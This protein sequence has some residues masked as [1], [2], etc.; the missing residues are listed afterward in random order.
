MKNHFLRA[1]L[2]V[3][4]CALTGIVI[5]GI[6]SWRSTTIERLPATDAAQRLESIRERFGR[7]RPVIVLGPGGTVIDRQSLSN[8]GQAEIRSIMVIT[9]DAAAR[10]FTQT[11]IP[12]WFFRIKSP[13]AEY[14][15]GGTGLDFQKLGVTA[16]D[17]RRY[18]PALI[19]DYSTE[20][21]GRLV[22]WTE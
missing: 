11:R 15:F 17:L 7:V 9:Y 4:A 21:G 22:V 14:A 13:A 19:V 12:F 1:G 5:F 8:G 20:T 16:A 18:G 3:A 2:I 10:R 6:M